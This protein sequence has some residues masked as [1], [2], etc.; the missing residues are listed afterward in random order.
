MHAIFKTVNNFHNNTVPKASH[1]I[2]TGAASRDSTQSLNSTFTFITIGVYC[3]A[4]FRMKV[5]A[6]RHIEG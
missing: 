6:E 3:V 2:G 5:V 1:V 4:I